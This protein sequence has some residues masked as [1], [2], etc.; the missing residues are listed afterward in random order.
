MMRAGSTDTLLGH[1]ARND[2]LRLRSVQGNSDGSNYR[3]PSNLSTYAYYLDARIRGFRDLQHDIVYSQNESNRRSNGLGANSKARRLRHLAVDKGLLREVKQVQ[4]M[5]DALVRCTFYDDNLNDENTVLAF[6]LL[7]KDL[8]VLFQAGNEGVCNILEHYF[9]MSKTD[10][11]DAF[12]IY[13]SFIKQTDKIVDYLAI[14]R[15]LNNVVN[16]PVPNLKHAPTSLV[17]ALEEYLN[18]PNFENNRLEY[19]SSLRVVEGKGGRGR[20]PA[21]GKDAAAKD[22]TK[23]A[24]TNKAASS[25]SPAPAAASSS[26]AAPANPTQQ[27]IQDFLDSIQT[28]AQPTIFGGPA[29]G[30]ATMGPGSMGGGMGMQM[31]QFG[32]MQPM[33]TGMPMGTMGSVSS[34]GTMNS[35]Q[36]HPGMQQQQAMQMQMTGANPFRQSMMFPQQTGFM[37]AGG[38]SPFLQSQPTGFLQ[39]QQTGQMAFQQGGMMG[40]PDFSQPMPNQGMV[41]PQQQN[42][43]LQRSNTLAPQPTSLLQ[44]S[45]TMSNPFRQSTF[46]SP[47][48]MVANGGGGGMFHSNPVSPYPQSSSPEPMEMMRPG[49]T[50]A[51]APVAKP[52]TAQR[53]GSNNPFAPPGGMPLQQAQQS[54]PKQP[55]MNDMANAR[56]QQQFAMAGGLNPQQVQAQAQT[57]TQPQFHSQQAPSSSASAWDPFA[58]A[59]AAQPT[60]AAPGANGSAMSDIASAFAI[61]SKPASA[62]PAQN[63][64]MAQFGALSVGTPPALQAQPTGFLQP[65]RTGYGGSTIKPFKPTSS[66]GSTLMETLPPIPEPNGNGG[67]NG[68]GSAVPAQQQQQQQQQQS[69]GNAFGGGMGSG[70][71]ATPTGSGPTSPGVF[72]G[73]TAQP[74]GFQPTSAFGQSLA[75]QPA[76]QQQQQQPQ[77]QALQPQTTGSNPFRQSLMPGHTGGS[78]S[79][80]FGAPSPFGTTPFAASGGAFGANSPFAGQNMG[81]GGGAFGQQQQQQQFQQQRQASLF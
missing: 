38:P 17:K 76:Q 59:P 41:Q 20:S 1:L 48:L 75:Q 16:V 9:E 19:R 25:S 56:F 26:S 24:D 30:V 7:I 47:G 58:P 81:G 27:K 65:Q 43:L 46:G 35:M 73:M 22:A 78:V 50:P 11:T 14:A 72:G 61:D 4:R 29:S 36:L 6:R 67:A 60:A 64:F 54:V 18:D 70:L 31:N 49:S 63:D 5:L 40:Q 23:T 53:T 71:G 33:A 80:A 39:P 32:Q 62:A 21:G 28:D 2:V 51:A 52:L 66:F 13:K 55:S 68:N 10:A 57:Q 79:G 42:S 44:R 37:G 12:E 45:N 8:L 74:T 15:R 34:M 77:A 69:F 3:P